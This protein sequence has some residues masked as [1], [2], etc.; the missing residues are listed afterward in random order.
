MKVEEAIQVLEKFRPGRGEVEASQMAEALA[1]AESN[2]SLKKW[3]AERQAFDA[4][5]AEEIQTIPVPGDLHEKLLA[6]MPVETRS[7]FHVF[8]PALAMAA[9]VMILGIIVSIGRHSR[10]VE[11][12]VLRQ[13]ILEESWGKSPHLAFGSQDWDQ[14]RS[15]L[16]ARDVKDAWNI[17]DGLQDARLHGCT[18]VSWRGHS[19][20][21]LRLSEGHRHMHLYVMDRT[22]LVDVPA[23]GSP[24]F[25]KFGSMGTA[26]WTKADKTYVLTGFNTLSFFKRFR[27]SGQWLMN[28]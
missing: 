7:R 26:S 11:F 8:G 13:H 6:S 14:V 20:P 9:A 15:W 24:Q 17:P 2:R 10:P 16:A 19:V 27:K 21:V 23:A 18:I 1:L 25:E 3:F 28:G 4:V 5:M 22:E 12:A